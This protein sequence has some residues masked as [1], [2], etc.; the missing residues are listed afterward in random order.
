MSEMKG[1]IDV[2]IDIYVIDVCTYDGED[3]AVV[4]IVFDE[5]E[6]K[7]KVETWTNKEKGFFAGYKRFRKRLPD[8]PLFKELQKL[9]QDIEE[10][11]KIQ[12]E[13]TASVMIVAERMSE[14]KKSSRGLIK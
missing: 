5:E 2:Y 1:E 11:K 12:A 10:L 14:L 13:A 7:Q 3:T 4:D 6:A 9:A 8:M